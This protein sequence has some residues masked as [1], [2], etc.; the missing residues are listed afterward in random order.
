MT[1]LPKD[2]KPKFNYQLIRLGGHN[3]G[4]YLVGLKSILATSTLISFGIGGDV[5]FEKDFLSRKKV[6]FLG[7]DN[8]NYKQYFKRQILFGL[9]C[10]RLL[11]IYYFLSHIV[12]F[13]LSSF[14]L[15]Y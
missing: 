9:P 15:I 13:T 6:I 7:Y 3:D 11:R 10:R 12:W 14:V 5:D 2:L 8:E 4:G 1:K